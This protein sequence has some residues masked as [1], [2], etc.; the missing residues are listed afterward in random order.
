MLLV[1]LEVSCRQLELVAYS[2]IRS[3]FSFFFL[4]DEKAALWSSSFIFEHQIHNYFSSCVENNE[5]MGSLE[6][7][8][9][10]ILNLFLLNYFAVTSL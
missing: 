7:N 5:M 8:L 1:L 2:F 10:I 6:I 9:L 3:L 4:L